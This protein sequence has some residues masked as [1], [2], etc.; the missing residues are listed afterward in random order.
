MDFCRSMIIAAAASSISG[1]AG[2]AISQ[3]SSIDEF[4]QAPLRIVGDYAIL[5]VSIA[6]ADSLLFI[7]DTGAGGSVISPATRALLNPPDSSVRRDTIVGAGGKSLMESVALGTLSVG[8]YS[9]PDLRAVVI[10]LKRFQKNG[11]VTY[12]GIL[13]QDFLRHFDVQFDLPNQRIR[14]F[15]LATSRPN[16]RFGHPIQ[17]LSDDP[18]WLTFNVEVEGVTVR[19]LLDTGAPRSILNWKAGQSL[20]L[21]KESNRVRKRAN[22]TGG[23]GE[24]IA[25]THLIDAGS[26]RVGS[27]SFGPR[28][29]RI[30]DLRVFELIGLG[31]APSMLFG[32][33]MLLRCAVHIS[34]AAREIRFCAAPIME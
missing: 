26:V 20:G 17:N 32:T 28:E 14:F 25:E 12:A 33:D 31:N 3:K 6:G 11:G 16:E 10:D 2:G 9:V 18:S 15:R 23:L 1:C 5:P 30:A 34:Y 21:S 7:L 29:L 27:T 24:A 22:G 19:A 8:G 13:G 4:A